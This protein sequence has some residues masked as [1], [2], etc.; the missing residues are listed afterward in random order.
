MLGLDQNCSNFEFECQDFGFSGEH[1]S[2][3]K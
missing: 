3:L 2:A 1:C